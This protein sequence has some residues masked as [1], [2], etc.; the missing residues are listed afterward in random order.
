MQ[1][2]RTV[3]TRRDL[4][5]SVRNVRL[6]LMGPVVTAPTVDHGF[7]G[8]TLLVFATWTLVQPSLRE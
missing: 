4:F 7:M 5:I 2:M 8:T 6:A 3:V 1:P